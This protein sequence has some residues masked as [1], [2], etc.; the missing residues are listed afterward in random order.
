MKGLTIHKCMHMSSKV[1]GGKAEEQD[2]HFEKCMNEGK[3]GCSQPVT[4]N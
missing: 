4:K 1:I 3:K 2:E